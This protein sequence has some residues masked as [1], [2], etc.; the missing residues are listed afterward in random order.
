MRTLHIAAAALITA[1]C[2]VVAGTAPAT[3]DPQKGIV[4]ETICDDGNTYPVVQRAGA[5][6][7]AQLDTLSG[8]VFHLTWYDISFEVTNPD[9]TVDVF[10]PFEAIKGGNDRSHKDLLSCTFSFFVDLGDGRTA[11]NFGN[12]L[13]WLTP[14][15][16]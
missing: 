1:G 15:G 2:L 14:S 3:A 6:W 13:G 7:N 16:G 5:E 12:A 10:G 4:I 8:S 9:G 11:I